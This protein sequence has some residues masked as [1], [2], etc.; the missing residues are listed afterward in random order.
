[1]KQLGYWLPITAVIELFQGGLG[2][3]FTLFWIVLG[4]LFVRISKR[5]RV[6]VRWGLARK[7]VLERNK[8]HESKD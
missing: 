1:M 8:N 3:E 7:V 6:R 2:P 4:V 5:R